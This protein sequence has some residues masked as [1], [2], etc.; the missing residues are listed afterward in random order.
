MLLLS[1]SFGN[2]HIYRKL[3]QKISYIH[4]YF[5]TTEPKVEIFIV[6][7]KSGR[8]V[9]LTGPGITKELLY[10]GSVKV[11]AFIIQFKFKY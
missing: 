8:A 10:L 9:Q 3:T 1:I 2:K 5:I 7:L 6:E 4:S 11:K